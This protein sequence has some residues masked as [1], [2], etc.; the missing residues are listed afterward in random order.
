MTK[1][2]FRFTLLFLFF[3]IRIRLKKLFR[4]SSRVKIPTPGFFDTQSCTLLAS[5]KVSHTP[6][7]FPNNHR[8]SPPFRIVA[9]LFSTFYSDTQPIYR[10]VSGIF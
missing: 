2:P 5:P 3:S 8:E 1:T 9:L 10:L 6:Q 7:L 4:C